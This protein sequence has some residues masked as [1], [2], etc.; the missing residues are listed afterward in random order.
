MIYAVA[1]I[2]VVL[3]SNFYIQNWIWCSISFYAHLRGGKKLKSIYCANKLIEIKRKVRT[4][5]DLAIIKS[6]NELIFSNFIN[7][8]KWVRAKWSH[9]LQKKIELWKCV[10]HCANVVHLRPSVILVAG[11]S[12]KST[13]NAYF[14][15]VANRILSVDFFCASFKFQIKYW[16]SCAPTQC[17]RRRRIR[18]WAIEPWSHGIWC[19]NFRCGVIIFVLFVHLLYSISC[20]SI[21]RAFEILL[22]TK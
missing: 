8:H 10:L 20:W 16:I 19:N 6:P 1:C 21:C 14:Q 3:Q 2:R 15:R 18:N 5:I 17:R 7:T 4:C 13:Q 22:E 12:Q 9:S 11:R